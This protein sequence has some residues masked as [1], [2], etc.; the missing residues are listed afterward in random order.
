MT[1]LRA[2][3]NRSVVNDLTTQ[4]LRELSCSTLS[5]SLLVSKYDKWRRKSLTKSPEIPAVSMVSARLQGSPFGSSKRKNSRLVS[6]EDREHLRQLLKKELEEKEK[7]TRA[8][9]EQKTEDPVPAVPLPT[10]E[11]QATSEEEPAEV[12]K[13]F[14]K[15]EKEMGISDIPK[16]EPKLAAAPPLP[17][18]MNEMGLYVDETP[19]PNPIERF[20]LMD[21]LVSLEES[22]KAEAAAKRPAPRY[23]QTNSYSRGNAYP[24][25]RTLSP[26][27]SA[28]APL[29]RAPKEDP[30][31]KRVT[32]RPAASPRVP[33][34]RSPSATSSRGPVKTLETVSVKKEGDVVQKRKAQFSPLVRPQKEPD[35]APL[36][37]KNGEENVT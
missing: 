1:F 17:S 9:N 35:F 15:F 6:E 27:V 26:G 37:S 28:R 14:E 19:E 33:L 12:F 10:E 20:H 24:S 23:A 21:L 29:A 30:V 5:V 7:K 36:K 31:R 25:H 32:S 4:S 22:W 13:E 16:E 34:A 3:L 8:S 2:V 18:G 11:A